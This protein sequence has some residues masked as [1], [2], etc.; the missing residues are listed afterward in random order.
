MSMNTLQ[1]CSPHPTSH[2][3]PSTNCDIIN[4][5]PENPCA[6]LCDGHPHIRHNT[7]SLP[8]SSS[9]PSSSATCGALTFRGARIPGHAVRGHFFPR[10]R[11]PSLV[12]CGGEWLLSTRVQ[13]FDVEAMQAVPHDRGGELVSLLRR[14]DPH[15]DSPPRMSHPR[16]LRVPP[17]DSQLSAANPLS[18]NL[19]AICHEVDRT[20]IAFGGRHLRNPKLGDLGIRR[21]LGPLPPRPSAAAASSLSPAA[22]RWAPKAWAPSEWSPPTLVRGGGGGKETNC[23]ERRSA[24]HDSA[25]EF[26]GK[27]SVVW[28]AGALLLYARANLA[29]DHGAR[30]VQVARSDDGGVTWHRFRLCEIEGYRVDDANNIY[31]FDVRAL[32]DAPEVLAAA[33][34][35]TAAGSSIPRD[36]SS[37]REVYE[38]AAFFPA[39]IDGAGGVFVSFGRDGVHWS[40]PERLLESPTL[41]SRTP[42]H[43]AGL[44]VHADGGVSMW[45][46]RNV[47]VTETTFHA[48]RTFS[49]GRGFD[50]GEMHCGCTP[51]HPPTLCAYHARHAGGQRRHPRR[52]A[53]MVHRARRANATTRRRHV[54]IA[55]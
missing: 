7:P 6:D 30:H 38:L 18:H 29:P 9:P 15:G 21:S 53:A 32:R 44:V 10:E 35:A 34:G 43:P 46:L 24:F 52:D 17:I 26:D 20:L 3:C 1:Q 36:S 13:F 19:A 22:T 54:D 11:Y 55:T 42:D 28:H 12:H 47:D 50:N 51:K 14:L 31:Y 39:V 16:L 45:V 4:C 27:L 40:R 2:T 48:D 25:C 33:A 37:P 23:T 49:W 5:L 8:P 41:N